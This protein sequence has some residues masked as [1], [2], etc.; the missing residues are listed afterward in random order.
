LQLPSNTP[1]GALAVFCA[2]QPAFAIQVLGISLEPG[3]SCLQKCVNQ[4]Q[5]DLLILVPVP[6]LAFNLKINI[7]ELQS[8]LSVEYVQQDFVF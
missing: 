5:T 7:I 3:E 8:L 1:K 6:M 2:L 4:S